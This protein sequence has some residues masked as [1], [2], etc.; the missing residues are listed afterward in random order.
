[1]VLVA[2]TQGIQGEET[3]RKQGTKSYRKALNRQKRSLSRKKLIIFDVFRIVEE[4]ALRLKQSPHSARSEWWCGPTYRT[5]SFGQHY[6]SVRQFDARPV[7]LSSFEQ[8]PKIDTGYVFMCPRRVGKPQE[9][10][11]AAYEE[12][13]PPWIQRR[14]I[15][16][17]GPQ[18][19]GSSGSCCTSR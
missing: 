5:L 9:S 2:E 4:G 18:K 3:D 11:G 1:M 6:L 17:N 10:P 14:T 8:C 12:K 19:R 7:P 16:D 13:K 15:R